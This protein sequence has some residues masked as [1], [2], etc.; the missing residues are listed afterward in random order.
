MPITVQLFAAFADFVGSRELQ[1]PYEPGMNCTDLWNQLRERYPK[2]AEVPVLFAIA[3]EYVPADT[4][5]KDGD[6]VMMFPPLSGGS[7]RHIFET[8]LSVQR[9]M[10]AIRDDNGGGEALFIGRVRRYSEGKLI[11]HLFYECQI[12]MAEK[13]ISKI[14]AEMNEKWSLRSVHIEHRTGKLEVGDLAVIIAVSAEHRKEALEACRYGID[15]LKRRV[16]IWKKEV[17]D[18]GEEWVGTCNHGYS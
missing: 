18:D 7:V 15:E 11:K 13:E 8:P 1:F 12:S 4:R 5:L 10:E 3:Q 14:I 2:V 9:A 17:S 6:L 16:P